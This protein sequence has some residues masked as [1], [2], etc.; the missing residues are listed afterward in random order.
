MHYVIAGAL[1][2]AFV[3]NN[4]IYGVTGRGR[5]EAARRFKEAQNA[6][7][8]YLAKLDIVD[9]FHPKL[10]TLC[11][12]RRQPIGLSDGVTR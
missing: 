8:T 2:A 6:G 11:R 3:P 4:H 9:C 12:A 10:R 1:K 5:D 7:L